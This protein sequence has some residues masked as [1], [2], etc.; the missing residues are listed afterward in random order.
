[1]ATRVQEVA[2]SQHRGCCGP[3]SQQ[4]GASDEDAGGTRGARTGIEIHSARAEDLAAVEELLESAGLPRE[5]IEAGFGPAY[6]VA[7][8]GGEVVGAAGVETY[9]GEGLLRSLVVAPEWRGAGVGRDLVRDRMD[10]A[11]SRGM[12]SLWLLTTTAAPFFHTF[13]F[14]PQDRSRAPDGIRKSEEFASVCP[15]SAVLMRRSLHRPLEPEAEVLKARV[16]EKYGAA[17]RAAVGGGMASCCGAPAQGATTC[18]PITKDLYAPG[19][20]E[21]LPGAAVLASLGCGNPTALASIAP[22]ETVLDL[23]SGGGIDVLLSARRVGPEGKVYGLDMTDEMLELAR[24]NQRRAGV[25]NAEFLKGDIEA[26]PLPDA[27][28]DLVISNCVINLAADKGLVL[29]EAFRVLRPG[30]RFAVSDIV[31]QGTL[32]ESIRGS[33]ELWAGCVA[34][35]LEVEEYRRLLEEAGFGR[36]GI[37]PTRVY[38]PRE[39]D[40][41]L[42]DAGLEAAGVAGDE[43]GRFISAFIRAQRPGPVSESPNG[44]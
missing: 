7:R 42:G 13:G 28:V 20:T 29:R 24:E 14:E 17:A 43:E 35:A 30:G 25:E 12:E 27:S 1:M 44:S 22:G 41:L 23:G 21:E 32:S 26:I 15:D 31:V 3:A 6:A 40:E 36:I 33:M 18:N 11:R 4:S 16:R 10:W 19:E 34:G 9:D 37:E 8:A 5:G 39:V 38:D 2:T